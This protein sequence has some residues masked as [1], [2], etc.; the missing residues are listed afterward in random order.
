MLLMCGYTAA[1]ARGGRRADRAA[2]RVMRA[3]VDD[4]GLRVQMRFRGRER[5]IMVPQAH[6]DHFRGTARKILREPFTARPW[7]ELRFFVL[8][9]ALECLA[10]AFILATMGAGAFL[11]VTFLGLSI[12]AASVRGARGIGGWHRGLARR[13]L[14]EEIAEPDRFVARPG[15]LGWL[16]SAFRDRTGWRVIAYTF[17]KVPIV[18][19][20]AWFAFGTWL[21]AFR[22]LLYPLTGGDAASPHGFGVSAILPP[23][24]LSVSDGGFLHTLFVFVSGVVLFFLAPWTMRVVIHVDRWLM[25]NLLAPDAVSER[26]RSLE[27]ARAHTV[28]ASAATL[29]RIE[30]DLHDGTQAQLVALA[31]RLGQAK[32]KLAAGDVDVEGVRRLVDEAHSGAKEAIIELRDLARG[33]HPPVLDTG[34]EGAL[35]TLAARSALPAELTVTLNDRPTPAIEAIAYFCVAELLANVAQHAHALRATISCVQHGR[36]LRIAVRDDGRGGAQPSLVGSSSSGLSGLADRVQAVDGELH[37]VSPIG[38]PTV[39]NVDIPLHA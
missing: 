33:I 32:E 29:R 18:L 8:S 10:L 11:A 23:G 2:R 35:A 39:V 1:L 17:V 25:R 3:D 9:G 31:M 21:S 13:F 4:A 16:Q 27:A 15:F 37:I 5:V 20:G 19:F 22:Y 30:R 28:D 24:Y 36:W 6:L 38:G 26:M 12:I 14:D 34:L 7:R